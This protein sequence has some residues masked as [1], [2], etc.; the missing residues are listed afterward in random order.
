MGSLVYS[1]FEWIFWSFMA[2]AAAIVTAYFFYDGSGNSQRKSRL[3]GRRIQRMLTNQIDG[4]GS[5][6]VG[7]AIMRHPT[8]VQ[9]LLRSVED[10]GGVLTISDYDRNYS[11]EAIVYA[12]K[13]G[14]LK[15]N[16][17]SGFDASI[18]VSL[19]KKL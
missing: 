17:G 14:L 9:L 11:D 19:P 3:S 10:N 13:F 5:V 12:D 1:H 18:T 4:S 7:I 2:I 15:V 6:T 16:Y 8:E